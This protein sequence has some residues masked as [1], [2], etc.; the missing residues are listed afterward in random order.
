M[1]CVNNR[2]VLIVVS[3]PSGG[4]KGSVLKRLTELNDNIRI[5]VSA[6]TRAPREGEIDGVNYNFISKS[7]F[8][9]LI[10]NR[11]MLEYAEYCGN[12]YG[13]P[14]NIIEDWLSNGDDVILEI[15]VQGAAQVREKCPDSVSVF[16][17]PPSMKV[18]SER[19][20]GRGTESDEIVEKRLSKAFEEIKQAENY[21][22]VIIN[23]S[24]DRCVQDFCNII[25]AEK[26]K[27][28]RNI[29]LIKEVLEND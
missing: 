13:T 18:L 8:K 19:L 15:E 21:D 10:S 14:K 24:L 16:I 1:R 2:G 26:M 12:Y 5:S 7:E 27:S 4:G 11:D 25:N 17:L 6:T 23:D 22:Y 28:S 3:S 29:N 9:E 20:R